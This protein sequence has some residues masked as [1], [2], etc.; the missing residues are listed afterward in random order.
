MSN[1]KILRLTNTNQNVVNLSTDKSSF[2]FKVNEDLINMG[3]CVVEVM[4]ASVQ[5]TKQ[6][7]TDTVG[8][9][10]TDLYR[11]VPNN[12]P[13]LVLRTNIQQSGLDSYTGGDGNII[14]TCNLINAIGPMK[15]MGVSNCVGLS[16]TTPLTFL[17][18]IL[19]SE[20]LVEKLFY[21]NADPTFLLPANSYVATVLPL[22]ID[23]KLTFIDME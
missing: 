14:G 16:Q 15:T 22:Q 17:C 21:A 4:G 7:L 6:D 12:I 20:I 18:D 19:P 8:S 1:I 11:I 3:R 23:L 10:N 5:I 9:D 2:T 13:L